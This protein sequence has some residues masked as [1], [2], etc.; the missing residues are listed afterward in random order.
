MKRTEDL[1]AGPPVA[2]FSCYLGL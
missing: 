1:V 2:A